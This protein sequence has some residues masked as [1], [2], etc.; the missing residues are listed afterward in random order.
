M[1]WYVAKKQLWVKTLGG[2]K[3]ATPI[4]HLY[5]ILKNIPFWKIIFKSGKYTYLIGWIN[6]EIWKEKKSFVLND[7]LLMTYL[8][9]RWQFSSL[10]SLSRNVEIKNISCNFVTYVFYEKKLKVFVAHSSFFFCNHPIL[11]NSQMQCEQN[12]FPKRA[13]FKYNLDSLLIL[14]F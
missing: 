6:Q 14:N 11:E 10:R 1:E 2:N 9:I 13:N 4:C 12:E 5:L 3:F 8:S 7:L